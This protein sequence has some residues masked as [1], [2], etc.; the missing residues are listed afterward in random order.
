MNDFGKFVT[1]VLMN[2]LS[3]NDDGFDCGGIQVLS[4]AL[5]DAGHRV[6]VMAPDTDRSGTSHSMSFVSGYADIKEV[7]KDNWRCSGTPVDCVLTV[8]SGGVDFVPDIVV[9]GINAGC[10]LGTDILFSGTAAA[11]R[12]GA[13]S[14]FPSIAFSMAGSGPYSYEAA[15]KWA[16]E[17]ISFFVQKWQKNI[18]FNVN[19]PNIPDISGDAVQ[20]YP[21]KRVYHDTFT[22]TIVKDNWLRLDFSGMYTETNAESGSDMDIVSKN[23]VS[24]SAILVEPCCLPAW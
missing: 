6:L 5:R 24:V 10:N 3:T 14:G 4:A 20:T 9:S 13:L 15:A 12:Q 16:C 11:A 19:F 18:F 7:C 17:N 22:K 2:I 8:L 1:L 21:S 23:K